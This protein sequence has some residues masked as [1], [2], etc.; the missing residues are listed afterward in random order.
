MDLIIA[1]PDGREIKVLPYDVDFQ[2]GIKSNF[3]MVVPA[4]QW[5]ASLG[6]DALL[7]FP[8]TEY[9]GI[10]RDIESKT[11]NGTI[12]VRGYTWRGMMEHKVIVPPAG[13]AYLDVS[14]ELNAVVRQLIGNRFGNLFRVSTEST[15]VN[16]TYQFRYQTLIDGIMDMLAGVGYRLDIRYMQE[17]TGGYVLLSCV[18]LVNY[19]DDVSQDYNLEFGVQNY[20]MGVNHLICLGQG[21]LLERIVVDLYADADGN[22]S[23]TQTI[24]GLDEVTDVYENTG[25]SNAEDLEEGGRKR[26]E[27]LMDF[28]KLNVFFG[29][30]NNPN[31]QIGDT[32]TGRDY[33]TGITA[34]KAIEQKI[35]TRNDNGFSVEYH[36]EG[37]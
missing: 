33:I 4:T 3:E 11:E 17:G 15:G 36:V 32:V 1:T 18:P 16:V 25:A 6:F 31:Y 19:G 12:F 35:L 13:S 9:G 37:E 5:D 23:T 20:K 21:E 7:Y 2:I 24:T 26:L 30:A 22:I 34:T 14:G 28:Q 27:E 29:E 10:I 8:D